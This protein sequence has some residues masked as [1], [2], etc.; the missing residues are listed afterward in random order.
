M[1]IAPNLIELDRELSNLDNFAISFSKVIG[2]Q[3]QYVIVSGYVS[4]LL[5]RTRGSEDIDM[6]IPEMKEDEWKRVHKTLE[7]KGYY[8]L[9]AGIGDSYTYLMD[10][11]AVRFAPKGQVMPNM[12]ILFAKEK[13]QKLALSTKI[14]ALIGKDKIFI[15]NLELQ[16]A[17]KEKIL[18]S[19]KDIEDA[20]H[21][22]VILGN[23]INTKKLKYYEGVLN[24]KE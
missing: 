9:N 11:I 6:L 12:E 2:E 5:G 22:R 20:R 21:L 15:S 18:G 1:K 13:V 4:I 17:Y 24:E 23:D 10:G 7:K 19:Q 16:I 3:T 8:C 14:T